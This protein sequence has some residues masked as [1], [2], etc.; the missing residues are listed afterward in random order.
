MEKDIA[1]RFYANEKFGSAFGKGLFRKAVFNGTADLNQPSAKYLLDMLG[2]RDWEHSAKSDE[3]MLALRM[4][5]ELIGTNPKADLL[6]TFIKRLD[7]D[8]SKSR[9]FG[10]GLLDLDT[11]ELMLLIKDDEKKISG[12]WQLVAKS[13]K[14]SSGKKIP[15]L[16]ATNAELQ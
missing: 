14:Q 12:A 13:C 11:K 5:E 2:Y 4:A 8:G 7:S 16:L 10:F 15:Q 6:A 1:V 3:D 9:V